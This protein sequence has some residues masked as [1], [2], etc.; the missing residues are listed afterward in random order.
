MFLV[1][2]LVS[3]SDLPWRIKRENGVL[4]GRKAVC[5]TI[6]DNGELLSM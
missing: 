2:D 6:R 3:L 4:K 5:L 1:T